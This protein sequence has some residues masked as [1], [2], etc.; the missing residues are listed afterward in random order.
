MDFGTR[1][2]FSMTYCN[3][4]DGTGI[5]LKLRSIVGLIPMFAVEVIEH[6]MLQNCLILPKEWTGF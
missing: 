3:L 4:T 6:E 2:R 5:S 1:D